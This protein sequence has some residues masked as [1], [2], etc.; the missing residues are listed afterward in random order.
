SAATSVA[1]GDFNGDGIPDLVVT[2][3][4]L[5]TVTIWKGQGD[6]GFQALASY[7]SGVFPFAVAVRGLRRDRDL[8]LALADE[9]EYPVVRGTTS[10]LLGNGDGTFAPA[11]RYAAGSAPF[12]VT[13]GDLNGD[14]EP[15]LAVANVDSGSVSILI[16]KGNGSF[17]EAKNYP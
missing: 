3:W 5:N 4:D 16:G 17:N 15:D 11:A 9:G 14:G 12:A 8:H 13:V 7:P 1:A 2:N 6:G 10:V